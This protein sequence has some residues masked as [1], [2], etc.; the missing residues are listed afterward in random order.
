MN[1]PAEL[2]VAEC[3]RL[4]CV[5]E[6]TARKPGNVHRKRSFADLTYDD[7][8][9]SARAIAP[10]MERA[11][12]RGVGLTVL[13]AIRETRKVVQ[14]NTNLGIVLLLAPLAA[15]PLHM[16]IHSGI[17]QVLAKL[18]VADARAVYEAI[19]LAQPGGMG[20]SSEQD[21]ANEPTQTLREVMTLAADRDLIARQYANGFKE[22]LEI[23]LTGLL[24]PLNRGKDVE[25]A[26]I[27]CQL[28]LLSQL[29][30]SLIARKRGLKEAEEASRR[31]AAVLAGETTSQLLV[32]F[33]N[34]LCA[35]GNQRNP[36]TT[37]DLV[38]ASLFV[39]LREGRIHPGDET[40][41]VRPAS[42]HD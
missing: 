20:K 11:A 16:P 26:I 31:A 17:E 39:G 35:L 25:T 32:E 2:T 6:V 40:A 24:E 41:N 14:T 9:C 22:V 1:T 13:E 8:I 28:Q 34:W 4:A 12:K 36:G 38:T 29:P 30:D 42:D 33:D 10:V 7:F 5:L 15:V 21:I 18:T 37:A 23:G 19:R 3:A 27:H